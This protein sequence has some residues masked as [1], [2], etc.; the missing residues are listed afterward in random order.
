MLAVCST[1]EGY[2]FLYDFFC[3]KDDD[4]KKLIR[5]KS[6]DNPYLPQSY[7][8]SL[9]EQ[10]P[11]QL[12]QAYLAGEFCNLAQ[13]SVFN[14]FSRARNATEEFA[15]EPGDRVVVGMDFNIGQCHFCAGVIRKEMGQDTL[16]FIAS[17]VAR[18]TYEIVQTLQT[19]FGNQ[20]LA[21][22]VVVHPDAAGQA[23]Q[24][25]S[26]K[27]DH[28]IL[29]EGGLQVVA[30][31]ANPNV[32]E[33][34]AHCNALLHHGRVKVNIDRCPQLVESLE[35]WAYDDNSR[36]QKGGESD[37]S[38]AGDAFRYACWSAMGGAKRSVGR[39]LRQY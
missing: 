36:P 29:R 23:Q 37:F 2:G 11:P 15:V 18:D 5:A 16:H 22:R 24:T 9:K 21:G 8:D 3:K 1:P 6:T 7:I 12:L 20:I 38:H 32:Q 34:I 4:S 26:T 31:R 25:A 30:Q 17:F 33:S 35:K 14:E 39:G 13:S 10:Y 19:N 27:T 28:Q